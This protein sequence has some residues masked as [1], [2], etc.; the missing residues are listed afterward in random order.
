MK[1]VFTKKEFDHELAEAG[2]RLVAVDFTADWCTKTCDVSRRLNDVMFQY[3]FSEVVF[4]Q[5]DVDDNEVKF[6]LIHRKH[7]MTQDTP[8]FCNVDLLPTIQFYRYGRKVAEIYEDSM[9]QLQ[10]VLRLH[11]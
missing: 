4:L 9:D 11:R 3:E 1:Q 6:S 7:N 5:V 2:D 10:A 8:P